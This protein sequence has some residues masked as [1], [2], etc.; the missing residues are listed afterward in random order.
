MSVRKHSASAAGPPPR[1]EVRN[2]AGSVTVEAVEGADRLDVRVEPLDEAAEELLDRVEIEVSAAEPDRVD[3]PTRLRITV[4][5]RRLARTPAF[6]ISITTPAGASARIAVASAEVDV[7]GRMGTLE[8]TAASGDL[9]VE[10]CADLHLR[11]ASGGARIGAVSGHATVG[12]A[13]GD[14]RLGRVEG[15]LDLRTASGDV[16]VD[17]TSGSVAIRSASGDVSIGAAAGGGIQL[18]TVSGDATV[19]V[20]PGLRVWLDLS[21]VSGRMESALDPEDTAGDGPPALSIT[22]RSVSGA[23]RIHPAVAPRAAA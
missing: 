10:S 1:I 13:S 16:S 14:V 21:T 8:L 3:S 4:P 15:G 18:K 11:N 9:G 2:P 12:T 6:A 20:V 7:R 5:E 19:G 17:E 22:M 23:L